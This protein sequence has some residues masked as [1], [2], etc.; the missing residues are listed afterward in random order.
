[1]MPALSTAEHALVLRETR[2]RRNA[3]ARL[4]RAM[5]RLAD[6]SATLRVVSSPWCRGKDRANSP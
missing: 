2:L 6:D 1:M 5:Q 3:H 4:A